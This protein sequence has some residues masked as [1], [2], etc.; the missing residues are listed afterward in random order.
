MPEYSLVKDILI[1]YMRASRAWKKDSTLRTQASDAKP[2][3]RIFKAVYVTYQPRDLCKHRNILTGK[4]I[5]DYRDRRKAE[6]IGP[7][8]IARELQLASS[9]V[10][11][12]IGELS[13]DVPN[14]FE[15][16]LI[17]KADAR[18]IK[19]RTRVLDEEQELS[20]L[21][22]ALPQPAR[23]M[24][25]LYLETGLRVA[26]CRELRHDQL[27]LAR[28]VVN[29]TPEQHKSGDFGASAL[30]QK[31]IEIIG[32]QPRVDRSPYVFNMGRQP[33]LKSWLRHAWDRARE[34]AGCPD[35]QMRDLRRTALT[36]WR[37]LYGLAAT[38]A[39]AR[40]KSERTTERVYARPS[41]ETALEALRLQAN[42]SE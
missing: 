15:G 41:V 1:P 5:A 18:T 39:Q 14:L 16:R 17:T 10:Q 13:I 33:V 3:E 29:F 35:L 26:E 20:A 28:G 24:V 8:T 12:A 25:L 6:G 21:L 38:Q 36:K 32:R 2:I 9:A 30:T 40:H 4:M 19:P 7:A 34:K 11:Y 37:R 27:D 42:R 23:D 31:A 22:I